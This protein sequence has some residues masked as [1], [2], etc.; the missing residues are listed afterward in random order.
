MA[1]IL[2]IDDNDEL[3]SMLVELLEGEGYETAVARNG[4]IGVRAFT[5][6]RPDLV[7]TD[8][9][10]P[11]SDGVEAIR[12]IRSIDPAARIVAISGGSMIGYDYYLR[13]AKSLGAYEVVA[14]PFDLDEFVGIV[15]RCLPDTPA[16]GTS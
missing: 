3:C 2:I 7:I 6:L 12:R 1:T 4:E 9:V 8:M 15:Q 5:Q 13:V 11:D 16:A 14:K 10:M